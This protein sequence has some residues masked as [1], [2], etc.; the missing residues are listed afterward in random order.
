MNL[1]EALSVG[2]GP[3]PA[4]SDAAARAA[5]TVADAFREL[6]LEPRF[7]EFELVGYEADEPRARGGRRALAR[8]AVHVRASVRRRRNGQAHRRVAGAGRRQQAPELRGRRRRRPRG[9][10]PPDEPVLD[11]RDPVHVVARADHDAADGIRL[12]RRLGAARGRDAR[13]AEGRRTV[14][15]GPSRAKR[16]RRHPGRERRTRGRDRALRLGVARPGRD[17]QCH[18]VE[19]VRRIGE[20]SPGATSRAA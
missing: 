14:R 19:G 16:D 17:R 15:T 8:R 4:G 1:V 13:P 3:R 2:V 18:R 20:R 10:A 11:R 5:D 7:Q 9:C 6:G 12:D